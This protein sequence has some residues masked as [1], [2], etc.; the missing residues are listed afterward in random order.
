VSCPHLSRQ[1]GLSPLA[2]GLEPDSG[3]LTPCVG[4]PTLCDYTDRS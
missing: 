1:S 4:G 3:E 2:R